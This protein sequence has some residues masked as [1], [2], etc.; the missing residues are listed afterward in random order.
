MYEDTCVKV[1]GQWLFK[2]RAF[3][4]IHRQHAAK[5]C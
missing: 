4:N 2:T 5:G 3:R 1:G